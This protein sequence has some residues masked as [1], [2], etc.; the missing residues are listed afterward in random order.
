[1]PLTLALRQ[2]LHKLWGSQSWL[3]PAFSRHLPN[4]K[5]LEGLK[6]R[7]SRNCPIR[8][9]SV[10]WTIGFCGPSRLR[11]SPLLPVSDSFGAC[12]RGALVRLKGGCGQ[13]C[14]PHDLCR[15]LQ[16]AK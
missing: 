1:M 15:L 9:A 5:A 12:P 8:H 13:E 10:G 16:S 4:R 11:S 6:S 3:P 14:P 7:L 2:V